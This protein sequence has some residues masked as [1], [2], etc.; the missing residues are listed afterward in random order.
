MIWLITLPLIATLLSALLPRFAHRVVIVITAVTFL[1]SIQLAMQVSE[2]GALN[3]H[4]GGWSAGLAIALYAD[5]LSAAMLLMSTLIAALVSIYASAYFER[6]SRQD[7]YWPLWMLL[8]TALNALFLSADLFNLYV[9][10]ELLGLSAAALTALSGKAEAISAAFRYLMI[11]LIGSLAFLA[12]VALAYT[13]Y[14]TLDI[15]FLTQ[16]M[17][18]DYTSMLMA[19]MMTLG[20]MIKAALLPMHFWLPSAHANAPAPVSAVLSALVVKAAV[21]L[22]VRLWLEP[23]QP[24]SNTMISQVF[25]ILGAMAIVWG[26]YQ[27]F[28]AQRLKLLAAY[29]TVAQIGYLFLYLSLLM[30]LPTGELFDI[31]L[32]GFVLFALS[33]GFAKG[34]LFLAAG[35]IQQRAGHDRIADLDGTAQRLPVTTFTLALAGIA[36][37]G[38]PPSGAFLGKWHLISGAVHE[39]LWFLIVIILIGSLLSAA[40][41]FRVLGHAFGQLRP[42]STTLA[43]GREEIP[44]LLLSLIATLILGF[45]AAPLTELMQSVVSMSGERL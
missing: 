3:Y 43:V 31:L 36:L 30:I 28:S 42:S 37:I 45:G 29:S 4:I 16:Y 2:Q 24:L 6:G 26:S 38:L 44:A 40:Y 7:F 17:Q 15:A 11:G 27:A 18:R 1:I 14:G 12:G 25:V 22:I 23:F 13:H 21:Y 34:A 39:G 35:I 33:H 9:T 20:L 5:G 32:G 41:V 10:L 19:L 8:L